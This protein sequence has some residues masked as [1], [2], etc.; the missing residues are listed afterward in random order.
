MS[1][2]NPNREIATKIKFLDSNRVE[3]L[4]YI[5]SGTTCIVYKTDS[6]DVIKEFYPLIN[7]KPIVSR[8]NGSNDY[9]TPL[10]EL[11]PFD[12]K[13]YEE[14]RKTFDSEISIIDE[15]KCKYIGKNNNMFLIPQEITKTSLGKCHKC[16]Y[17]GGDTL[18]TIFEKSYSQFKDSCEKS[19][20]FKKHFLNV[21]PLII[22]LYN[23]IAFYHENG[24]LNLDVKPENL[25]V[26]NFDGDDIGVRN[27]DFGSAKRIE[28]KTKEEPGLLSSIQNHINKNPNLDID[29]LSDQIES[30]FFASSP[31]FYDTERIKSLIKKYIDSSASRESIVSDLKQLDILAAWKTFLFAFSN[32]KDFFSPLYAGEVE[33]YM[34]KRIF[35]NIFEGNHLTA[36]NSLFESYYIYSELNDIMAQICA[37]RREH[38]LTASQVAERLKN[39]LCLLNGIPENKKT[40]SQRKF[41]AM[42][43]AYCQE[44]KLLASNNLNSINDILN[45]CRKHKI[46]GLKT[47]ESV[48]NLHYFLTFGAK[49]E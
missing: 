39:I 35:A 22:S 5:G 18:Q 44:D 32:S 23:E 11:T 2:L 49:H 24:I 40:D 47:P 43:L 27:L 25:F 12:L 15:L 8:K 4:T 34:L 48:K 36:N 3:N 1:P 17:V 45:F 14:R 26:I 20:A 31:A 37:G 21:L 42:D 41:E 9:L 19:E 46:D 7:N 16:S 28:D 10:K 38:R 33:T 6:N 29:L 30:K 13:L